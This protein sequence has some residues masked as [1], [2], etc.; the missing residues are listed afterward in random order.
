MSTTKNRLSSLVSLLLY[1]VFSAV[2][3][4]DEKKVIHHI[5]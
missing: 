5:L 4:V 1:L 2:E 3:Q